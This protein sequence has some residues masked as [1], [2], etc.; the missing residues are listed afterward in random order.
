MAYNKHQKFFMVA[1]GFMVLLAVIYVV[2]ENRFEK[3]LRNLS[4]MSSKKR[5]VTKSGNHKV[6]LIIGPGR[7]GTSLLG[8]LFDSH[9]AF[10]YFFEPMKAIR[11]YHKMP[12]VTSIYQMQF[13][14][15][16][17]SEYMKDIATCNYRKRNDIY[18]NLI[19]NKGM[20]WKKMQFLHKQPFCDGEE[21]KEKEKACKNK[22]IDSTLMNKMCKKL[23]KG[24]TIVIK[25]LY[26]NFPYEDPSLMQF[27][28]MGEPKTFYVLHALRDPRAILN[29]WRKL[30][31]VTDEVRRDASKQSDTLVPLFCGHM[32]KL[33]QNFPEAEGPNTVKYS[34]FRYDDIAFMDVENIARSLSQFLDLKLEDDIKEYLIEKT[35]SSGDR[36]TASLS[37][38]PRNISLTINNWRKEIPVD[39]LENIENTS[40]CSVLMEML[41]FEKAKTEKNLEDDNKQLVIDPLV[42]DVIG[43]SNKE[44]TNEDEN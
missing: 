7:S 19:H 5:T 27:I 6:V 26:R 9:E 34:I 16:E 36:K 14:L 38:A 17:T 4:L 42:D 15:Q 29:S 2:Q 28:D 37:L 13:L 40:S 24:T 32:V 39:L 35:Q 25:E 44:E 10:I 8:D 12:Q 30:N 41:G 18:I 3:I 20:F 22:I 23:K 11:T 33:L 1:V 31:W 21:T 43:Y